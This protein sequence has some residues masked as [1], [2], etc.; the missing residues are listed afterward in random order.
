MCEKGVYF[1]LTKLYLSMGSKLKKKKSLKL[2]G[3]PLQA[4]D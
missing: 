1:S 3:D 2:K 4:A